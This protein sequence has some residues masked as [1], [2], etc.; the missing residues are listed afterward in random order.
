MKKLYF[1]VRVAG[2]AAVLALGMATPAEAQQLIAEDAAIVERGACQLEAW[3]GEEESWILPACHFIPGLEIEA[4]IGFLTGH[5][6][7]REMEWVVQGK[8]LVRETPTNGVGF[9]V[10]LGFEFD[11]G[12]DAGGNRLAGVYATVPVTLSLRDDRVLLHGNL[13]WHFERDDHGHAHGGEHDLGHHALTWAARADVALPLAGER[14][15]WIGEIVGE[16]RLL[17]EFQVGLRAIAIPDRL[18]LE[19]TWGGHTQSDLRGLG[20]ILGAAWTPPPF[21]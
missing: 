14:V 20:W 8:Y 13:G 21:R 10:I 5:G 17:P 9:G 3:H 15:S 11:P 2:A 16:D 4:G 7:G 18:A 6:N 12:A 19:L 1:I